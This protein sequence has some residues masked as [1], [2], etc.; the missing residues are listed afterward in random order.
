MYPLKAVLIGCDENRLPEL[1]HELAEQGVSI[2]TEFA[3][4]NEAV[5]RLPVTRNDRRLFV[6]YVPSPVECRQLER[7]N[8]VFV[9][10]PVLALLDDGNDLSLLFQAMRAGAAQVVLAPLDVEDFRAALARIA[11]QFGYSATTSRVIAV[12]GVNEGCG[13][14]TLAINLAEEF[15][16]QQ[17]LTSLLIELSLGMGR[18]ATYLDID[19]RT[20]THDLLS[21]AERLDLDTVRQALVRVDEHFHA[22]A[23]P[24]KG[25][26][27]H[28]P[29]GDQVLRLV[30]YARRL[31]QV[32]VLDMPYTYDDTY[33]RTLAAADAVVLVAE[34]TVPAVHALKTLRDT[35][36][37][38]EGFG[39]VYPVIN[40]YDTRREEF[41][42]ERLK[43]LLGVAELYTI[44]DDPARCA[45]AVN[46]GRLLRQ[47]APRSRALADISGLTDV[48]LGRRRHPSK[49][50]WSVSAF[51]KQLVGVGRASE[52]KRREVQRP[53]PA[54]I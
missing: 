27:T 26:P 43:E 45:A 11:R 13:A 33:F 7:L 3:T 48:L 35:L 24:F 37:Q 20:T 42:V 54:H 25:I 16:S 32:V 53:E 9:G 29:A 52:T 19:P 34:Q 23:G 41:T 40:R 31:A 49:C 47:A 22:L 2:E 18:L 36:Q 14:T 28:R 44:A 21:D 46:S 30:E 38:G 6:Q 4:V 1:R 17:R 10:R 8:N 50:G 15:A 5:S 12:T 51:L 39:T